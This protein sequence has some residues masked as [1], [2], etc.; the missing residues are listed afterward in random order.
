[1]LSLVENIV[2]L[3]IHRLFHL[4]GHRFRLDVPFRRPG[5]HQHIPAAHRQVIHPVTAVRLQPCIGIGVYLGQGM[6]VELV[7]IGKFR[8]VITHIGQ[9][10][11]SGFL[12]R[13]SDFCHIRI[14]RSADC[15]FH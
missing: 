4:H 2:Q 6:I 5:F 12:N 7:I 11:L 8:A 15:C 13:Q 10:L 3:H 9:H 1:M 14:F